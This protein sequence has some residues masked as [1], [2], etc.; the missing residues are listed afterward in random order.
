MPRKT[1][2]PRTREYVSHD[3]HTTALLKPD[4][5][6][7]AEKWLVDISA[8]CPRASIR[9]DEGGRVFRAELQYPY[10]STYIGGG[11]SIA[12]AL[13]EALDQAEAKR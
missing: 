11:R 13:N 6:A 2:S 10:G 5:L 1:D 3:P 9:F 7:R 4:A 8:Y 12:A